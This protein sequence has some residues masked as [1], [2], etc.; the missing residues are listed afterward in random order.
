M[1]EV[2]KTALLLFASS[3]SVGVIATLRI[4]QAAWEVHCDD[5]G[6]IANIEGKRGAAVAMMAV[7][8]KAH[9]TAL[10]A[11]RSSRSADDEDDAVPPSLE[12]WLDHP[13]HPARA[14]G[15]VVDSYAPRR[16]FT[17]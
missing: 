8:A 3:L 7:E 1:E 16:T 13:R 5:L 4:W 9:A 11:E 17:L 12:R 15:K 14:V 10:L 6:L 2:A